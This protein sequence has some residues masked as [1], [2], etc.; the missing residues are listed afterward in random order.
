MTSFT[1]RDKA[2]MA[3]SLLLVGGLAFNLHS[4]EAQSQVQQPLTVEEV[5]ELR[6][7]LGE[8]WNANRAG[9]LRDNENKD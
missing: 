3:V 5:P 2:T 9:S 4:A 1:G 7:H 8:R 6:G